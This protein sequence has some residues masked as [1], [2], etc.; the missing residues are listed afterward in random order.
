[1]LTFSC[2]LKFSWKS[3]QSSAR[4]SHGSACVTLLRQ[5]TA[6]EVTLAKRKEPK[7][8]QCS[9]FNHGL[10]YFE[11]AHSPSTLGFSVG[12]KSAHIHMSH[13]LVQFGAKSLFLGVC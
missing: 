6:Q 11:L 13:A 3:S 1:M 10:Q 12:E 7:P 2:A 5:Q 9:D 8:E 4:N